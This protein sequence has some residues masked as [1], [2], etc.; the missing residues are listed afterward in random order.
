MAN[1]GLA[2]GLGRG[3]ESAC[4]NFTRA[5]GIASQARRQDLLAALQVQREQLAIKALQDKEAAIAGTPGYLTTLSGAMQPTTV[6][7]KTFSYPS[8]EGTFG[9]DVPSE[10]TGLLA[11]L[12][13]G[14]MQAQTAPRTTPGAQTTAELLGKPGV[15]EAM[16]GLLRGLGPE[17]LKMAMPETPEQA[18]T[19]LR[20]EEITKQA[21]ADMSMALDEITSPD[22]TKKLAGIIRIS[23][24][25]TMIG[26]AP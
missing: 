5:Y 23:R 14:T 13:G 17:G 10:A 11:G 22:E 4:E 2:L 26:K 3:L 12:P 1:F 25:M 7:G 19:R 24:A 16:T 9:A 18:A 20:T 8:A 6:P 21:Q 15:P